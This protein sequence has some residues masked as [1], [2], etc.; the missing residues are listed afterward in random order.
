MVPL[1]ILEGYFDANESTE[2]EK[3]KTCG[4]VKPDV[5]DRC[6]NTMLS[7]I[8]EETRMSSRTYA[9]FGGSYRYTCS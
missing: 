1:T 2:R 8:A 6:G 7:L 5:G 3:G 9:T 4:Q